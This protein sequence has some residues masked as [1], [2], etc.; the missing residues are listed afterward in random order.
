MVRGVRLAIE[1]DEPPS[2][3]KVEALAT[4][5]GE[6][7]ESEASTEGVGGI[8]RCLSVDVMTGAP[9]LGVKTVDFV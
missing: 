9:A 6:G 1:W 7:E 5:L 2:Q 4:G 3:V 8:L